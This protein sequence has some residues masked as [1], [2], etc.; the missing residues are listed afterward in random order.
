MWKTAFICEHFCHG[1]QSK[2]W[3]DGCWIPNGEIPR[4]TANTYTS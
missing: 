3:G 1:I 2:G 4:T